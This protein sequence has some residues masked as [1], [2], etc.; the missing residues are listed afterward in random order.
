MYQSASG[1]PVPVH[2]DERVGGGDRPAWLEALS[3]PGTTV[4]S[5][6]HAT[7]LAG[8]PFPLFSLLAF[9]RRKMGKMTLLITTRDSL[10]SLGDWSPSVSDCLGQFP[11]VCVSV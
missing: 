7:T 10:V 11:K 2:W 6:P 4:W 8:M 1:Q 5:L 3:S 9:Q